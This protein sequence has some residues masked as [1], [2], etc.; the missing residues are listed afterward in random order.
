MH[1]PEER[2]GIERLASAQHVACRGLPLALRDNPVLDADLLAGVRVGPAC[3]IA[4]REDAG[5][6]GFEIFVDD[7]AT[8]RREPRLLEDAECR[9]DTD[10]DDHPI[11]RTAV[12][13]RGGQYRRS[14]G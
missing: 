4:G 8:V 9:P 5:G 3:E 7:D 6:A 12:T 10:A 11:G 1:A 14:P 13:E 2:H